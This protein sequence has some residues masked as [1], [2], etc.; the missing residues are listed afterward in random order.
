MTG[1][2]AGILLLSAAALRVQLPTPPPAPT[3]V[4]PRTLSYVY[5]NRVSKAA[6]LDE[7]SAILNEAFTSL[8]SVNNDAVPD[9]YGKANGY[10]TAARPVI[11]KNGNSLRAKELFSACSLTTLT[12]VVQLVQARYDRDLRLL[13]KQRNDTQRKIMAAREQICKLENSRQKRG[14]TDVDPK[15]KEM[16][17]SQIEVNSDARGTVISV[18]DILFKTD[19]AALTPDL[20]VSLTRFAKIL[21]ASTSYRV[22]IEGHTDNRGP[23]TYNQTLSEQRAQNVL[24]FLTEQ[25]VAPDRLSAV[26]YGMSRP[27][28]DNETVEGRKKN[29]RV[30]L[31][32]QPADAGGTGVEGS[33]E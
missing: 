14:K 20:T 33:G 30:D 21:L 25:G 26:G 15:F 3:G 4:A 23:E 5:M 12:A 27:I 28:G 17:S 22:I 9:L 19:S 29:R 2:I 16:Q 24:Q 1:W 13:Q 18:S 31:V 7:L 11:E 8:Y 32:V 6:T 10:L